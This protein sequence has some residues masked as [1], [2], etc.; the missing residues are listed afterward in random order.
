MNAILIPC[1]PA[2]ARA[3]LDAIDELAASPEEMEAAV[4]QVCE[5]LRVRPLLMGYIVKLQAWPRKN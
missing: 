1:P 4:R 3:R 5:L 2:G